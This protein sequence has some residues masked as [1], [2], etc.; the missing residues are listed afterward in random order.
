MSFN[1]TKVFFMDIILF[2]NHNLQY[3]NGFC[4]KVSFFR[5]S[6]TLC[7]IALQLHQSCTSSCFPFEFKDPQ[8]LRP[9][10]N[11]LAKI[12][13]YILSRPGESQGLLY[14][15]FRHQLTD[16][17]IL[18]FKIS[19]WCRHALMVGDCAFSL[20]INYPRNLRRF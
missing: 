14:K 19:F 3:N 10:H 13:I 7:C 18:F 17:F 6:S 12:C 5:L 9:S 4:E 16:S 8:S 15:H 20:K 1:N 2:L 11:N